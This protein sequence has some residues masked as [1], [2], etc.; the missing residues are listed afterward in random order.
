M[1]RRFQFNPSTCTSTSTRIFFNNNNNMTQNNVVSQYYSCWT[2]VR[3]AGGG[4]GSSKTPKPVSKKVDP[5]E[6]PA[7]TW[8]DKIKKELMLILKLNLVLV[9]VLVLGSLWWFPPTS[10]QKEKELQELYKQSAGWKT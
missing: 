8:K 9:P 6:L 7:P 2:V 5:K 1:L 4:V 10:P 3:N